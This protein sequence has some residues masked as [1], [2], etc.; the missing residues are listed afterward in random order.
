[1]DNDQ[2]VFP[3]EKL[4][5]ELRNSVYKKFFNDTCTVHIALTTVTPALYDAKMNKVSKAVLRLEGIAERTFPAHERTVM[6]KTPY[7]R[8]SLLLAN[9][10]IYREALPFLY[11]GTIF[12]FKHFTCFSEFIVRIGPNRA[13]LIHIELYGWDPQSVQD[14]M[15]GLKTATRL[16]RLSL[17]KVLRYQRHHRSAVKYHY[18]GLKALVAGMEGQQARR[19]RFD[20]IGF[21][22]KYAD[23]KPLGVEDEKVQLDLKTQL[24]KRLVAD[25]VLKAV[26][27]AQTKSR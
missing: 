19:S 21:V 11:D 1:M 27:K 22:L 2:G 8:L 10:A 15:G 23:G 4:P 9:R 25:K 26:T 24:E 3:F 18:K 20:A 17:V 7:D 13:R 16:R 14:I 6:I 5:A 12:S